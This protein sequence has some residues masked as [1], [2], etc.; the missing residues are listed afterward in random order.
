MTRFP[1]IDKHLVNVYTFRLRSLFTPE[2]YCFENVLYAFSLLS[3]THT[4]KNTHLGLR[5]EAPRKECQLEGEVEGDLKQKHRQERLQN[6][7]R[8]KYNPVCEPGPPRKV[9]RKHDKKWINHSQADA[10]GRRG[11][12]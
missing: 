3:H 1:T 4:I 12:R 10:V 2:Y 9:T 7:E 11:R 5:E 8:R 6:A